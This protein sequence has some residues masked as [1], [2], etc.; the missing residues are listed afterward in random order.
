MAKVDDVGLDV[1]ELKQAVQ[2]GNA[3]GKPSTF[4]QL[5]RGAFANL[6]EAEH[7]EKLFSIAFVGSDLSFCQDHLCGNRN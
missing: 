6:S 1:K 2:E 3:R 4:S 5:R 7:N